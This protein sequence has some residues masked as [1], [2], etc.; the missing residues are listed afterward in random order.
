MHCTFTAMCERLL[1][2]CNSGAILF[3]LLWFAMRQCAN[4]G[5][6]FGSPDAQCRRWTYS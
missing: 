2:K 5:L 4:R 3:V 6:R 1:T